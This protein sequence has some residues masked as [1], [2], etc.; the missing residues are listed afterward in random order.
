MVYFTENVARSFILIFL[1]KVGSYRRR[2]FSFGTV[3][4]IFPQFSLILS[5]LSLKNYS[6]W[7]PDKKQIHVLEIPSKFW[8]FST[9]VRKFS[10]SF[11]VWKKTLPASAQFFDIISVLRTVYLARWYS[12]W[13]FSAFLIVV[14]CSNFT[15]VV[16]ST[17]NVRGVVLDRHLGGVV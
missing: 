15:V 11:C 13:I 4:S 17:W 6:V 10:L 8:S 14:I 3:R 16:R 2:N 5:S 7:L 9:N 1:T 12:T